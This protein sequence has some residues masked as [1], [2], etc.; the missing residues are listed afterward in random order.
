MPVRRPLP[1]NDA[2]GIVLPIFEKISTDASLDCRTI[3]EPE[4][5]TVPV[6]EVLDVEGV[7]ARA[8][9]DLQNRLRIS[10]TRG[11]VEYLADAPDELALVIGK[12][13]KDIPREQAMDH[14]FGFM[15]YNDFSERV[16]QGREMSVGLG[17]AKGK[18]F[19][20]AHVFG[21]YLATKDE[22]PAS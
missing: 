19:N 1:L 22:I 5:C 6:F 18:D 13:G 21:P 12:A 2:T 20:N 3:A 16:I 15:I 14:V 10:L 17:P 7:N 8:G 9:Y 11:L 4:S